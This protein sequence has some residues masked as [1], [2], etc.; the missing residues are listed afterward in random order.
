MAIAHSSSGS[1]PPRTYNTGGGSSISLSRTGYSG[2]SQ[3]NPWI[4]FAWIPCHILSK[5]TLD[6]TWRKFSTTLDPIPA[7][8]SASPGACQAETTSPKWLISACMRAAPIP[9]TR[10]NPTQY[11][12]GSFNIFPNTDAHIRICQPSEYHTFFTYVKLS[13]GGILAV[14]QQAGHQ[15]DDD[16]LLR[17]LDLWNH[18]IDHRQEDFLAI[19]HAHNAN[20]MRPA[21]Q[22]PCDYPQM[23]AALQDRSHADNLMVRKSRSE[24]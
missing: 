2:S 6:R 13:K 5:S 22:Y 12:L 8:L 17:Q 24:E 3:I 15:A 9:L 11:N 19:F 1:R 7:A 20:I 21:L 14:W 23:L 10:L 4:S 16:L 18:G